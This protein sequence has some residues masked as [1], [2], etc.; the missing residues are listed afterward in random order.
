MKREPNGT[1]LP[2]LVSHEMM[3]YSTGVI[4]IAQTLTPA[5]DPDW[6]LL[7]RIVAR[8]QDAL[9]ALYEKHAAGLLHYLTNRLG[10]SRLAEEVLQDTMLAVWQNA[11]GF[12]G[13]C[14]VRTWLITIARY[15]AINAY[16][17]QVL[18]S[19]RY[20]PF[21]SD[22]P[23]ADHQQVP[24]QY[25]DLNAALQAL[26]EAQ[27]ETLELVFYHGL[28]QDEAA[29]VLGIAPGTVKSRLHRARASLR[30]QMSTGSDPDE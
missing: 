23:P 20:V 9:Q 8:D 10:D 2:E 17:R 4:K 19:N 21:L 12:R 25:S 6:L 11:G 7:Q 29:R 16:H 24:V 1:F 5:I 18:P 30:A 3:S 28:P 14:R 26:P 22:D 13:E 15:R 27:R